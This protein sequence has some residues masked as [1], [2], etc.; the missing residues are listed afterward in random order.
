VGGVTSLTLGANG[1]EVG[2]SGLS[3]PIKF[4]LA[5]P[6]AGAGGG[7]AVVALCTYWDEEFSAFSDDGCGSL[8]NPYPRDSVLDWRPGF[9]IVN[10]TDPTEWAHAWV[11]D[12]PFLFDGCTENSTL[13]RR[14]RPA[15]DVGWRIYE[16]VTGAGGC[17]A[18]NSSNPTGCWWSVSTQAFSG[19]GCVFSEVQYWYVNAPDHSHITSTAGQAGHE[20]RPAPMGHGLL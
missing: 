7:G 2:V 1:T 16:T 11:I 14:G 8:P 6:G 19:P 4:T 17:Q 18:M 20:E 12:H 13:P 5:I 15:E 9:R 10:Q 3:E